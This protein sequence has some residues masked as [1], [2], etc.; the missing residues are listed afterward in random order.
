MYGAVHYTVSLKIVLYLFEVQD[1]KIPITTVVN[2]RVSHAAFFRISSW[3][4]RKMPIEPLR[5][6]HWCEVIP[7]TRF[8]AEPQGIFLHTPQNT[9]PVLSALFIPS[10]LEMPQP[11]QHPKFITSDPL[12]IFLLFWA[13]STKKGEPVCG[14]GEGT[15]PAKTQQ[16]TENLVIHFGVMEASLALWHLVAQ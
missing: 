13:K 12:N 16:E 10:W 7:G 11:P 5:C 14:H 4:I 9:S 3:K 15:A 6:S 8:L 2:C 1:H